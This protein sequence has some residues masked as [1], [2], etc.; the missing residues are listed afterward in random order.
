MKPKPGS[1]QPEIRETADSL[2]GPT[3]GPEKAS[4]LWWD[5]KTCCVNGRVR[6]GSYAGDTDVSF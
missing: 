4:L 2:V 6:G 5:K 1:P 3:G